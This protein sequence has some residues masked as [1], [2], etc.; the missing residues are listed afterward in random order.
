MAEKGHL[1]EMSEGRDEELDGG[2][3]AGPS[4]AKAQIGGDRGKNHDQQ[5][6]GDL[7]HRAQCY[8]A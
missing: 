1:A 6:A 7:G 2:G 8:A 4:L 5:K 3:R